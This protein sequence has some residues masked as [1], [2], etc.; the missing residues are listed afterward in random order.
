MGCD[1]NSHTNQKRPKMPLIRSIYVHMILRSAAV[2]VELSWAIF[3]L[4]RFGDKFPR[5][6]SKNN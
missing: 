5:R 6:K 3:N 4:G 1:S 2:V